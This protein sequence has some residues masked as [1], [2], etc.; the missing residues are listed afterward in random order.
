ME[1]I[2][3]TLDLGKIDKNRIT[4]RTFVNRDNQQ[5]TVKEYKL[6][7]V[8]VRERKLIKSGDTWDMVKTHFVAEPTTKDER[9]RG[10]QGNILGDGIQFISRTGYQNG[11][12]TMPAAPVA[13][14]SYDNTARRMPGV[15][16]SQRI[17]PEDIPF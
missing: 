3:I 11:Y 14:P 5:I 10:I 9:D 17:N 7:I 6:E 2:N 12:Q 4:T 8:P 13:A 16:T 1:K 15:D